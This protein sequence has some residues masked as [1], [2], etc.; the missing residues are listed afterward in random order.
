MQRNIDVALDVGVDWNKIILAVELQA[1]AGEI[2]QCDGV[3]PGGRHLADEF[4]E[5]FPQRRLIEIARA[6]DREAGGLQ[7][8]G[9]EAGVV[10]GGGKFRRFVFV[11]ADHQR[12]ALFRRLARVLTQR[13]RHDDEQPQ[14]RRPRKFC[15]F[16]LPDVPIRPA[17]N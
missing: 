1:D 14:G 12:E 10:G 7:R 13:R 8:V 2:D 4:P 15:H 6:G 5:G 16:D 17:A 11:V 9:D 3:R